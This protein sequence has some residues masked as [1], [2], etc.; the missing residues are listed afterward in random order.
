MLNRG[1]FTAKDADIFGDTTREVLS[2]C[3]LDLVQA[4][5]GA[6]ATSLLFDGRQG[7]W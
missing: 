6:L 3:G 5:Q 2:Q 1:V 7:R 4:F